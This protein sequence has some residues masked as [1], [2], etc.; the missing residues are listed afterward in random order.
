M[1]GSERN[2]RYT[3][4]VDGVHIAYAVRGEGPAVLGIGDGW[5]HVER[6]WDLPPLA[7]FW[8]RVASF[9]S[10][11]T[12]DLRG[13]SMSD[14]LPPGVSPTLEEWLDDAVAV[15]D[16]TSVERATIFVAGPGAGLGLLLAATRPERVAG[17]VIYNGF[18]RFQ[19]APDQAFGFPPN[20]IPLLCEI[21]E[22]GWGSEEI[23]REAAPSLE[24]T[25]EAL[26]AG[27]ANLRYTASPATARQLVP[28]LYGNDVRHIVGSVGVPTLIVHSRRAPI[29]PVEHGRYLAKAIRGARYVELSGRDNAF[30]GEDAAVLV[31][32]IAAFVTGAR[33]PGRRPRIVTTLF[34]CDIVESTERAALLGDDEWSEFL[35]RFEDAVTG[36]FARHRG[37]TVNSMGDGFLATFDG[38]ARAVSCGISLRDAAR[39]LGVDVR[40]GIH[41]GEVVTASGDVKGIA[42][43]AAARIQNMANPGEVL[44]SQAVVDVIAGSGFDTVGRGSHRLKGVPGVWDLFAVDSSHTGG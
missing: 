12:F 21:I 35:D 27:A 18:A 39:N 43:H 25:L 2:V 19:Q 20:S 44:V 3:R 42:V 7:R 16:A 24:W 26:E 11:I 1:T 4:T 30:W 40:V 29:I 32:E 28:A 41:I 13:M 8:S 23:V 37:R 15:M 31:D 33:R 6:D 10:L 36:E 5:G 17:I 38:P 22:Q 9:S 14:P 34:F